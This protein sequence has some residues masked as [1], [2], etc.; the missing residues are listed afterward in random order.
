MNKE[1]HTFWKKKHKIQDIKHLFPVSDCTKKS[2]TNRRPKGLEKLFAGE[3]QSLL[4]WMGLYY[5][6]KIKIITN[7]PN[8]SWEG[9]SSS[10]LQCLQTGASICYMLE[11]REVVDIDTEFGSSRPILPRNDL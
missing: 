3:S 1:H 9:A 10:L 4:H 6:W 11:L 2:S 5:T 7:F 8:E